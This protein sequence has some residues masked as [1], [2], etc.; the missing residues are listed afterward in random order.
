MLKV[1]HLSGFGSRRIVAAGASAVTWTNL[2]NVTDSPSGTIRKTSGTNSTFNAGAFSVEGLSGDGSFTYT[3]TADVGLFYFGVSVIDSDATGASID[4]AWANVT[5]ANWRIYEN[6]TYIGDFG[7]TVSN[8]DVL[9]IQRSGTTITYW[10]NG[11]S[12]RTSGVSSTGTIKADI[13]LY[14]TNDAILGV[15]Y[16]IGL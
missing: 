2:T 1:N 4:Y 3:K 7:G 15:T 5:A 8:G 12:V 11:T 14:T 9:K 10:M 13:S 16:Q 6:N